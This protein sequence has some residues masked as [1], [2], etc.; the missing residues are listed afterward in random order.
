MSSAGFAKGALDE[1][2]SVT[3]IAPTARAETLATEDFI[4]LAD[5]LSRVG[6]G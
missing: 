6:E 2:L 4:R 1:A 3:G 5:A